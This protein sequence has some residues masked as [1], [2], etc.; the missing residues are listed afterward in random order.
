MILD[1]RSEDKLASSNL[2]LPLSSQLT[3]PWEHWTSHGQTES[4]A[5]PRGGGKDSKTDVSSKSSLTWHLQSPGIKSTNARAPPE[6]SMIDRFIHTV[7]YM[8]NSRLPST[9]KTYYFSVSSFPS[10]DSYQHIC[11]IRL[12]SVYMSTGCIIVSSIWP[13]WRDF[14]ISWFSILCRRLISSANV[15]LSHTSH[16]SFNIWVGMILLQQNK[17]RRESEKM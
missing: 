3:S 6:M 15:P 7:F 14:H 13:T 5:L 17:K 16:N 9:D 10:Q 2:V 11:F 8:N 4:L 1:P 12:K